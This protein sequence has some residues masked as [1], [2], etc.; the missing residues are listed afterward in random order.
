M[1]K[2]IN[3][4]SVTHVVD[5]LTGKSYEVKYTSVDAAKNGNRVLVAAVTGKKI[6]VIGGK[7]FALADGTV[8][9]LST[10]TSLCTIPIDVAGGTGGGA[11]GVIDFDNCRF[12]G[13]Q[14]AT[15]GAL[16]VTLS[17]N[18]DLDG[19]LYYIEV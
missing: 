8:E 3:V 7:L 10:T 18:T 2:D 5:G 13:V 4:R 19:W 17:T 6:R 9:I 14:T 12:G 15:G 16:E 1:A 11:G